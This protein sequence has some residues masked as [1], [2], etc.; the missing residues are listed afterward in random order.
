MLL[1]SGDSADID[2]A[3]QLLYIIDIIALWGEHKYK[4]FSGACIR[5]FEAEMD[6][7]PRPPL[8]DTLLAHQIEINKET[9]PWLFP[10]KETQIAS[11]TRFPFRHQ[12]E[13][14]ILMRRNHSP[15][16]QSPQMLGG[17]EKLSLTTIDRDYIIPERDFFIWILDRD[18]SNYTGDLLIVRVGQEGSILPPL[19]I[20]N[21][22]R[23]K[24]RD[25][26]EVIKEERA[27]TPENILADFKVQQDGSS[28]IKKSVLQDAKYF[29]E[30]Q[31]QFCA[32]IPLDRKAY[33]R[34]RGS[35][36]EEDTAFGQFEALLALPRLIRDAEKANDQWC[37][38][39]APYNDY[40][41]NMIQCDNL[42]CPIGW[43]H[44]KCV[45]L[46]EEF[47]ADL[48][49]CKQC[50][51]NWRSNKISDFD[52]DEEDI[53]EE[54]RRASDARIQRVKTLSRVWE[55]HIWPRA[56]ELRETID[57]L[58]YRVII[59]TTARNT[60]DTVPK[61][62]AKDSDESKC[63]AIVRDIPKVMM[64]VRPCGRESIQRTDY[65]VRRITHR[66]SDC[67]ISGIRVSRS[68]MPI[69]TFGSNQL[70]VPR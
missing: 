14:I 47:T 65:G 16:P 33:D 38:C 50:K 39:K 68:L 69:E 44:N 1:W 18:H 29:R 27:R 23:W 60:F 42:K 34:Q 63:W 12:S 6:D 10:E 56:A 59:K 2:E 32:I 17:I 48:W 54:I 64:A 9:F 53:D 8:K 67:G 36:Y 57:R 61:L 58:S 22:S 37:K 52:D 19:V 30:P 13:D 51:R 46:D 25:F 20:F 5:R 3:L 24:R 4:P 43:Y 40:S 66:K 11:P 70:L 41:P 21:S 55:A 28:Y 31:I 62:K 49:L 45:D 7:K 26:R 35:D 15:S